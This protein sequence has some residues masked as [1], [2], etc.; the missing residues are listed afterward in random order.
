M[1]EEK[2]IVGGGAVYILLGAMLWGTTGT[3]Q[4]LAP[5]E[6]GP[7]AVGAVRQ[8][9]GGLVL[10]L[11]AVGQGHL[12]WRGGWT[13]AKGASRALWRDTILAGVM[14]AAYQVLFF[15]GVALAG[16]A[17]GTIV[18]IGSVP[19]AGGVVGWLIRGER[20][21]GRW[22][23]ATVLALAGCGLLAA[24]AEAE[25]VNG[26]G[27]LLAVGAGVAYALYAVFSKGVLAVHT[28]DGGMA[29]VFLVGGLFLAPLLLVVD[30]GWVLTL[31]GAVVVVHLGVVTVALAYGLFARGLR[32]V[33]VATAMTLTLAEPLTAGL[34]GVFLLGERL[35]GRGLV[36]IGLLISGLMVLVVKR[37]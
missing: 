23:V 25:V 16:V 35:T 14:M 15:S 7:L 27:L 5:A 34:L 33:T 18:G 37:R 32:S 3:T 8:G 12:D 20:P 29:L 13:A 28:P 17:V 24:P 4:A 19:I 1:D 9:V 36:G 21:D 10:L 6:A 26:W 30:L 22:L 2:R 11:V 31:S